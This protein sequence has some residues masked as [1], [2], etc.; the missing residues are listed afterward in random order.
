MSGSS[1]V[2]VINSAWKIT[3]SDPFV[4]H[5]YRIAYADKLFE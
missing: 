1:N 3:I 4:I 5:T 2:R